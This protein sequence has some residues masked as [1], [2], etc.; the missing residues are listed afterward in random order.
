MPDKLA[1]VFG[2]NLY[3]ISGSYNNTNLC[4]MK[5]NGTGRKTL[6]ASY[7]EMRPAGSQ[8]EKLIVNAK[9]SS[10]RVDIVYVNMSK[11]TDH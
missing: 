2:S 7:E 8:G 1:G 10:D 5:T 3:Y 4:T 6:L 11:K 9:A